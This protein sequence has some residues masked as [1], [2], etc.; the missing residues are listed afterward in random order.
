MRVELP[1]KNLIE[2][3]V[4]VQD[5]FAGAVG[6]DH[7]GVSAVVAAD[8]EAAGRGVSGAG[9]ADFALRLFHVA[10]FPEFAVFEDRQDRDGATKV[11]R[12]EQEFA[13]GVQTHVG[14]A[15]PAGAD[16]V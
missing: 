2:A 10:R 8:G 11:V 9:W 13:R 1:D 3:E 16:G 15:R 6:F 14:W 4:D 7:V 12:D 5:E